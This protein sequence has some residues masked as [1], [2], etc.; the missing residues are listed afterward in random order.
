MFFA[1]PDENNMECNEKYHEN[2]TSTKQKS[3]LPKEATTPINDKN[4]QRIQQESVD[5]STKPSNTKPS[6]T[7]SPYKKIINKSQSNDQQDVSIP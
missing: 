5:E 1:D 2:Q 4:C 6:N 3:Q 7:E